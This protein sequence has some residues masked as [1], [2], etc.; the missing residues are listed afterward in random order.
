MG[1]PNHSPWLQRFAVFAVV[2][3]LILIGM[4]GLVT[5]KEAGMAVYDWP[6]SFGYNMF[7]LPL[8]RWLG[9]GG[10]FE[11]HSHRLIA[12]LVAALTG[13]LTAWLW[14]RETTGPARVLALGT[15]F[16]TMGLM[17]VRAQPMLIAMAIFAAA[18]AAVSIFKIIKDR[19]ALRW[20]GVLASSMVIVQAVLGGLRVV[21]GNDQIGI[22]H[23]VLAQVFLVVLTGIALFHSRW[24][25][26]TRDAD[27]AKNLVP[28]V[29]R[30]HFLFATLLI[31]LQL[32]LGA[33][34][35]HQ[36][37]GLPIW[38]FPK[39]HGQWWPA[40]DEDSLAKYNSK[41][42]AL[43]IQLNETQQAGTTVLMAP[44]SALQ[45]IR[46]S[47]IHLHMF[48]R[49]MAVL[50]LGLVLGTVILA[51]RKLGARHFLSRTSLLWLGLILVQATLGALTVLKYKPAD[52][53]TLH[54][55]FGALS[56]GTGVLG[57]VISRT[58]ELPSLIPK[59]ESNEAAMTEAKAV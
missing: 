5:S 57:T 58:K 38:D 1:N 4:G 32:I 6:T 3:T 29:V 37:T 10:V 54:V 13:I 7:L 26:Q 59:T 18:L 17:G 20:W 51:H 49:V 55:L 11:E 47:E 19:R 40:T 14:I 33:T 25:K 8:D 9:I 27:S 22:F 31:F 16:L 42:K 53:A 12:M 24:W 23:G 46:A 21:K 39:A 30:S 45:P 48:H 44:K 41:R 36:H 2:C 35:R 28:R 52:I 34:M 43:Q 56:L 50:I 15:I